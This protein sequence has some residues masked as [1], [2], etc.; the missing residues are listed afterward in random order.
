[1]RK[2]K[3]GLITLVASAAVAVPAGSALAGT[4]STSA[5]ATTSVTC[6]LINVASCWDIYTGDIASGNL[7]NNDVDITVAANI[8]GVSVARL[9]I[10]HVGDFVSCSNGKK[11]KRVG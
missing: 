7:S 10:V 8:C 3:M 9:E 1:M 5:P 2:F 6:G 11:A 4:Q